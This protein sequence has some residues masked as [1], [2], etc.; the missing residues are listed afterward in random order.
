MLTTLALLPG[1]ISLFLIFIWSPERLFLRYYLPILLLLP[2][3]RLELPQIPEISIS[4]AALLPILGAYLFRNVFSFSWRFSL[5]DLL[6]VA[7]VAVC[8][9]SQYVNQGA[10]SGAAL[11]ANQFSS[12]LGTYILAKGLIHWKG[13]SVSFAKMFVTLI[14]IDILLTPYEMKFSANPYNQIFS[15]FFPGQGD[16]WPTLTRFGIVRISGPFFQPIIFGMVI[17][18]AFLINYW[19]TRNKLWE[20]K[21]K[22]IPT[23]PFYKGS[24]YLFLLGLG[25]VLT[26]S[27]GPLL[28][29]FL[30]FIFLG[31]GFSWHPWKTL[32][33]RFGVFLL[34]TVVAYQTVQGYAST[35]TELAQT[36]TEYT[37]AYRGKLVEEYLDIALQKPYLGWGTT[38]W[39][40]GK[41]A[42]T[43]DNE[44]LFNA[45]SHGFIAT[46]IFAFIIAY[47]LLRLL[48]VGL[49]LPVSPIVNRSLAFTFFGAILSLGI[50][51]LSVYLGMQIGAV[52]FILIGWAEG[53]ILK[54]NPELITND[55]VLHKVKKR[56]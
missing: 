5:M 23:L 36:D 39:Y 51:L 41:Y 20:N 2:Q 3:F 8:V 33:L 10:G 19:L 31:I 21:Y 18:T 15:H 44:F 4:Q 56:S 50:C 1:L 37:L 32:A 46:G 45:L 34:C 28:S 54:H 42:P 30:G 14:I 26:L 24:V 16:S 22:Y 7:Y 53:Y 55:P 29:T 48:F 9:Y 13:L 25:L 11:L 47:S 17:G 27:R 38:G 52:L 40:T 49:M 12:M 6:V 35:G 43:I